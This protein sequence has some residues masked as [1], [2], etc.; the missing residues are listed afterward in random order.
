MSRCR[1]V[2]YLKRS[3]IRLRSGDEVYSCR[4]VEVGLSDMP[5]GVIES[6]RALKCSGSARQVFF[7][8]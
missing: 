1:G 4:V 5:R 3:T 8:A 7:R 2:G 6:S